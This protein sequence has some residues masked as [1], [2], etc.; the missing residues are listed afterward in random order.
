ME[1]DDEEI[2][3][4]RELIQRLREDIRCCKHAFFKMEISPEQVCDHI[5]DEDNYEELLRTAVNKC[6]STDRKFEAAKMLARKTSRTTRVYETNKN[7]K[8]LAYLVSLYS[9]MEPPED[10]F[11]PVEEACLVLPQP[12]R[13]TP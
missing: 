3:L 6:I 10:Q 12:H 5:E 1:R 2:T 4:V 9:E 13:L 8:Q 7:N 11:G